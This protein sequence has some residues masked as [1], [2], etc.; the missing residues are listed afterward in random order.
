LNSG[1][2]LSPT[3]MLNNLFINSVSSFPLM[4]II[5]HFSL[6]HSLMCPKG[7]FFSLV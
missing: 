2:G 5:P 4:V 7:L 1:A 3:Q 6:L